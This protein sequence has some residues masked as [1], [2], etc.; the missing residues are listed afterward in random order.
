MRSLRYDLRH[1]PTS[2]R[3][4]PDAVACLKKA[5]IRT[6]ARLLE[7]AKDAKGRRQLAEKTGLAEKSILR[8]ANL[9]DQ[10]RIKGVG[11]DYANLLQAAGVD[12]VKELKYRNPGQARQSDGR[13]Q[14]EA[15]AGARAALRQGRGALD[16]AGQ[17]SC[18]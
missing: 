16:R 9:S 5:G 15:Q 18:R 12:T 2:P 14:C 6:T 3:I 10:M 8:W 4:D 7:T 13:G 1:R 17:A 11:E